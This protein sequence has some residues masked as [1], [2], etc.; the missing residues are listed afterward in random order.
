ME[1][2]TQKQDRI[3]YEHKEHLE[4]RVQLRVFDWEYHTRYR[5]SC[6]DDFNDDEDAL[7]NLCPS[8]QCV[9]TGS[10]CWKEIMGRQRC[11]A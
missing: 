3:T 1:T 5:A 4:Q 9:T 8:F 11:I 2:D 10:A 7:S 6:K